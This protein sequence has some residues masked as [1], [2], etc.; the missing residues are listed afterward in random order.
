M[1]QW[2]YAVLSM[3][4]LGW[5]F[6]NSVSLRV[7][8][9]Q[10]EREPES[11]QRNNVMYG[12][13]SNPESLGSNLLYNFV[14]LLNPGLGSFFQLWRGYRTSHGCIS[15]GVFEEGREVSGQGHRLLVDREKIRIRSRQSIFVH[16]HLML[17]FGLD[18]IAHTSR[19]FE[20]RIVFRQSIG[21]CVIPACQGHEAIVV[22]FND[23]RLPQNPSPHGICLAFQYL[24]LLI[25]NRKLHRK[26]SIGV[27]RSRRPG[28]GESLPLVSHCVPDAHERVDQLL[29]TWV[30]LLSYQ[31]IFLIVLLIFFLVR[32]RRPPTGQLPGISMIMFG[33]AAGYVAGLIA[34]L[35]HQIF[36]ENG[37]HQVLTTLQFPAREAVMAFL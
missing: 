11:F 17:T 5:R 25:L 19:Q 20:P 4:Q 26:V 16:Q 33:G 13:R 22:E 32:L 23:R 9:M 6:V 36:Q 14:M 8:V 24:L 15:W 18:V 34:F 1:V 35:L 3:Y 7:H 37:V 29:V 21:K 31:A 27:S 12:A 2:N 30:V 28:G 10:K